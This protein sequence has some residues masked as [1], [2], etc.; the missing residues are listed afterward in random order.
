MKKKLLLL[1]LLLF[2]LFGVII[3]IPRI[4]DGTWQ[5]MPGPGT[6]VVETVPVIPPTE[7]MEPD[8]YPD[9]TV[10]TETE[11]E[12]TPEE[13]TAY[14]P[15]PPVDREK[16]VT[17]LIVASDIHWM[18]PNLT[19]Y[20][21]A[22]NE[23]I[24]NG[25]GKVVRYIPEI[26]EAFAQEV[27][28]ARPEALVL[29]GD[30]TMNGEK[31]NHQELSARLAK[32]EAAGIPV[33]VIPGNH[34]INNPYAT[35]YFGETQTF[36]ET[37][38]PEEF[39]EIYGAYG[40]HE[41]ASQ[42]PDSLSYLYILNETTWMLM[43]DSC[44]YDPINEVDGE[45]KEGT[46]A[47]IEQCLKDAYAQG[48]TVVPVAHHNLQELSRVYVEECVIRNHD[49][50]LKLLELYLTPA[51]FSGHLHVQRIQKH[52][53]GP[54]MPAERYG[55]TEMVANSLII[56]PCQYARV[57]LQANGSISYHTKH[58]DISG[59]AAKR[60]NRNEDLLNFPAFSDEYIRSVISR[61]TY[62][63]IEYIPEFIKERMSDYYANLY[64][65]YYAGKQISYREQVQTEGYK[66]WKR[67][68]DPSV[69][70]RQI[71]G[72]LKDSLAVNSNVEI[73]N[74]IH[75]IWER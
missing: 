65:D 31:A 27:I 23:L 40:Y 59:W 43:I 58:T 55:I 71:E 22:F 17:D 2:A 4:L 57:T 7:T 52:A 73:P 14:D 47:W 49:E 5:T 44:I 42:A 64:R 54:G 48:I 68:M 63:Q 25:D 56:P 38:T 30:L 29:A 19:D 61:Q 69:Q 66:Y 24:D 8:T 18:S 9:E 50:L 35:S 37:V 1:L 6:D 70:F 32:I 13:T 62:N 15:G 36:V 67:F 16:I 74:P 53:L 28:A 46:M 72:M 26:W 10:P 34:D 41:A 21:N 12:T 20:G 51:F 45:I 75:Q 60:G 39:R 3:A 33:L 11:T